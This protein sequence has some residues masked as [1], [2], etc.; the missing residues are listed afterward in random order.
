MRIQSGKTNLSDPMQ[1]NA[2][3]I[4]SSILIFLFSLQTTAPDS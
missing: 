1:V 2:S 4:K 3:N